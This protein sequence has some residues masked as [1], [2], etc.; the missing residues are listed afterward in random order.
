M[1]KK[2]IVT[3]GRNYSDKDKVYKTLDDL[4]PTL[5]IH[6]GATGVDEFAHQWAYERGVEYKQYRAEWKNF[7]KPCLVKTNKYG[8]KY[9]ALAGPNRN[10]KM[11]EENQD[12][13][14]V[15]FPGGR[16]T[17]DCVTKAKKLGMKVMEIG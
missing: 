11:L 7:D 9:N 4:A 3:G 12:A 10:T 5:V 2:V 8:K 14:V 17:M 15:A 6:G 13:L 16:G 1:T